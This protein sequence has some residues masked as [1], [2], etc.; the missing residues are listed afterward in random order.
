MP[1]TT[2]AAWNK[3]IHDTLPTNEQLHRIKM[4]PNV[5]CRNYDKKDT[6]E[7]RLTACVEG[8]NIWE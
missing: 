2:R 4:T 3:V 6:L 7:H 5:T 1:E 8:N